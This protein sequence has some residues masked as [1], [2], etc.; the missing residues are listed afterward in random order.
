MMKWSVYSKVDTT[1]C[2]LG[3]FS[4]PHTFLSKLISALDTN[5]F[6]PLKCLSRSKSTP[7]YGKVAANLYSSR[8]SPEQ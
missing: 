3:K 1:S 5:Q 8:I 4:D 2:I 7:G 6:L